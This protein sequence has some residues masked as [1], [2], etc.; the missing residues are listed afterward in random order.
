MLQL[1]A[2]LGEQIEDAER[3]LFSLAKSLRRTLPISQSAPM[4]CPSCRFI[5]MK[6]GG[7][8][9][10]VGSSRKRQKGLDL[11]IVD[12]IQLMQGSSKISGSRFQETEITTALH[13]LGK[14]L[15]CTDYWPRQVLSTLHQV[16]STTAPY[17]NFFKSPICSCWLWFFTNA[18]QQPPAYP[19]NIESKNVEQ[20]K[21]K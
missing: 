17:A 21:T 16:Q 3:K 1:R 6:Q 15:K 18:M 20:L 19:Q 5:L 11:L 4:R 7:I 2:L 10:L 8:S 12:Y 13:A 14:E 9:I